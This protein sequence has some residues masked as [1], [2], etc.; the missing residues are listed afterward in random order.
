MKNLVMGL[1]VAAGLVIS[2][3]S[4]SVSLGAELIVLA[5][6]EDG[7]PYY[8]DVLDDIF[9]FHI[10][11]ARR[12]EEHGDR[13]LVLTGPDAYGDYVEALG[14]DRVAIAPMLD[15]WMRDFSP[16]VATSPTLFRYTAAGQGGDQLAS[17]EVAGVLAGLMAEAGL[18]FGQTDLLNDGGN[19]VDDDAGNL[20]ISRKFPRDNGLSEQEARRKLTS[21]G[22]IRNVAFIEAD[23]QGGLEHADGVVSFVDTNTLIINTYPEDP[24]YARALKDDLRRGLPGV[25]IHEVVTPYDGSAIYDERFG[26]AC[27][28]Y[29]NALVT[30]ERVYLP[31]FGIKEDAIALRQV[32][33]ATMRKVVPVPTGGICHMGGGVRCMSWQVRGENAARL[34]EYVAR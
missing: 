25:K 23:E 21:S 6:P 24:D 16:S 2:V 1:L 8:T 20:V 9:D 28:L 5:A 10:A 29:T 13:V 3:P 31:Q 26:S 17:D 15:I 14:E 33:A 11:F 22:D 27:G 19:I 32:Q 18:T 34:L 7:D 12:I 4:M 30:H